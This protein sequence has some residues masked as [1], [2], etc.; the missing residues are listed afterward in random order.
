MSDE[1]KRAYTEIQKLIPFIEFVGD[2]E[3]C[4]LAEKS[5]VKEIVES[6]KKIHETPRPKE[7]YISLE[8][9]DY[10]LFYQEEEEG[11]YARRWMVTYEMDSIE[12]TLESVQTSDVLNHYGDDYCFHGEIYL[13]ENLKN[14]HI[15]LSDDIEA[16]VQDAL[17]YKK[18]I[19]GALEDVEIDIEV[20]PTV[21][22]SN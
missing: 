16:F 5:K 8:L 6:I 22:R 13:K 4:F 3:E 18:Y 17:N 14:Q 15:F 9:L 2:H 19:K 11:I 7:W 21:I 1:L 12:I 10:S 20:W